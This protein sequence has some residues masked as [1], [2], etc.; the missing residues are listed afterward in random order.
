[1]QII[2]KTQ[3]FRTLLQRLPLLSA[4]YISASYAQPGLIA[5]GYANF[6]VVGAVINMLIPFAIAEGSLTYFLKKRNVLALCILSV[7]YTK[8][9]FDGGTINNMFFGIATCILA[10]AFSIFLHWIGVVL[11]GYGSGDIHFTKRKSVEDRTDE[12]NI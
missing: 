6:G 5:E 3:P 9:L 4:K 2:V 11:H 7:P 10:F 1:M 12:E 8:L